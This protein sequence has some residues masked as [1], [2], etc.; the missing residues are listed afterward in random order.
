[1]KPRFDDN[2]VAKRIEI[3]DEFVNEFWYLKK[4]KIHPLS[5]FLILVW[6]VLNLNLYSNA[7][8]F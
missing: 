5:L 2:D 1:M 3:R 6:K 8:K 4:K 7:L